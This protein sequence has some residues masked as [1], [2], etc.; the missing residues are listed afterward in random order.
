MEQKVRDYLSM[1]LKIAGILLL[2]LLS[3]SAMFPPISPPEV[4]ADYSHRERMDS[5]GNAI[6]IIVNYN[7]FGGHVDF[8]AVGA[9]SGF[10]ISQ[11]GIGYTIGTPLFIVKKMTCTVRAY[12]EDGNLIAFWKR[13]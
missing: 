11:Y 5:W 1:N 10:R 13:T 9:K 4:L 8:K 3:L 2:L 7:E 12:D 6:Q